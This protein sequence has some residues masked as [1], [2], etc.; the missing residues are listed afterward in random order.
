MA[1]IV[2]KGRAGRNDTNLIGAGAGGQSDAA[3]VFRE[4]L[5]RSAK[6]SVRAALVIA[7]TAECLRRRS[8]E[9]A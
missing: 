8:T 2:A 7:A 4:G 9:M 3:G 1:L 6:T 5:R